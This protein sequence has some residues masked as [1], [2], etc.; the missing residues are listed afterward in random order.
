M[1]LRSVTG[2][3]S[4]DE[5]FAETF[6][7]TI[8]IAIIFVYFNVERQSNAALLRMSINSARQLN[9]A[10]AAYLGFAGLS[11]RR[12]SNTRTMQ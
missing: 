2:A 1:L 10:A 5:F 3:P 4:S 9:A 11:S 7:P 8:A 6:N 12:N